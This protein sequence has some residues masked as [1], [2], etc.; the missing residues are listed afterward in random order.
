MIMCPAGQTPDP[1]IC[2]FQSIIVRYLREMIES[3]VAAR[4]VACA[5]RYNACK[6]HNNAGRTMDWCSAGWNSYWWWQHSAPWQPLAECIL[7][8]Y[9]HTSL[10][11][12][13]LGTGTAWLWLWGMCQNMQQHC[14]LKVMISPQA[15]GDR[16]SPQFLC[17]QSHSDTA[18]CFAML[19]AAHH[20]RHAVTHMKFRIFFEVCS[21]GSW[22]ITTQRTE[23][24]KTIGKSTGLCTV[25]VG[26]ARGK[27][28]LKQCAQSCY[29]Q[30]IT[31]KYWSDSDH[32]YK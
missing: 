16:T 17:R 12:C 10:R 32:L 13:S 14:V 26:D 3:G 31:R 30:E 28:Q 29:V 8:V 15:G 22:S 4:S 25:A 18:R 1:L 24:E 5:C 27:E 21:M 6:M 23:K 20:C 2:D 19:A 11:P 9:S 7:W